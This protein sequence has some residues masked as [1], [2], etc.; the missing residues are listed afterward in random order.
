MVP[1]WRWQLTGYDCPWYP[2]MRLFRQR[3]Q[4]DWEGVFR[5]ISDELKDLIGRKVRGRGTV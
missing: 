3:E 5:Q 1:D 4:G 2:T